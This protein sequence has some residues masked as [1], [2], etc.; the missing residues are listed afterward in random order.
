MSAKQTDGKY[1][2][3]SKIK[4]KTKFLSENDLK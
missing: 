1:K 4:T 2:T 3:E